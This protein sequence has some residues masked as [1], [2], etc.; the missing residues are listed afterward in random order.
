M[1]DAECSLLALSHAD[2]AGRTTV[3][4][5]QD[6]TVCP[7]GMQ[8]TRPL[9]GSAAMSPNAFQTREPIAPQEASPMEKKLNVVGID[10]AK[11]GN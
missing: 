2:G 10:M 6:E 4:G 5:E 1:P 3:T 7:V 8:W 11:Q 9:C